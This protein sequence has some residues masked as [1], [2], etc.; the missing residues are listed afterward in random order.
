VTN[1]KVKRI[2]GT[3]TR[4]VFGPIIVNGDLDDNFNVLVKIYIK[5][6]GEYRL[7]PFKHPPQPICE[8][9][10][11]E[12]YYIPDAIKVTNFTLPVPCPIPKVNHRFDF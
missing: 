7:M 11:N 6:G 10:N 12:K 8:F 5:Q 1:I 2:P 4:G 3:K 9:I